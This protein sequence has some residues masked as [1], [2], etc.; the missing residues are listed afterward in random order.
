MFRA[1]HQKSTGLI[2]QGKTGV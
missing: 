2:S 1:D